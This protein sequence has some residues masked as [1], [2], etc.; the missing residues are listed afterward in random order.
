MD[1]FTHLVAGVATPC[2]RSD[3]CVSPGEWQQRSE[4]TGD[5]VDAAWSELLASTTWTQNHKFTT[6]KTEKDVYKYEFYTWRDGV[7]TSGALMCFR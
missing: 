4:R 2:I 1:V 7:H 5:G 6:N 3:H